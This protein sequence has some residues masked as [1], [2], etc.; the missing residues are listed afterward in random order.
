MSISEL[1]KR[2]LSDDDFVVAEL[3][4]LQVLFKLKKE[5]RYAKER[6]S[7]ADTE[8]VA[9]HIYGMMCLVDYFLPLENQAGDWD[10]DLIRTMALYHDIDEIETGDII[11]Y[12]KTAK[13][14]EAEEQAAQLVIAKLPES[15]QKPITELLK[16]YHQ[17]TSMEA[18]FVKAI[19]KTEPMFHLYSEEGKQTLH[20]LKTTSEQH[21]G[22]K[23]PYVKEF[24]LVYRFTEVMHQRFQDEGYFYR[25][26]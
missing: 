21:L 9:E 26:S 3:K 7:D 12:L 13:D 24:P 15:V 4:K 25:G 18:K 14:E 6:H 11:G 8:S 16:T 20:T 1:R 19:D 22:I 23:L 2:L 10:K 17:Q 5:I